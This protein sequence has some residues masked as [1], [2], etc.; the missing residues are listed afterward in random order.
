MP[1]GHRCEEPRSGGP[2]WGLAESH[3]IGEQLRIERLLALGGLP[4]CLL[5]VLGR[6]DLVVPHLHCVQEIFFA[7]GHE[8]P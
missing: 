2:A 4:Q 6:L 1:S 7:L 8:D 3:G 5:A